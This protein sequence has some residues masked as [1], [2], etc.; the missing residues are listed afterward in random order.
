[1]SAPIVL[2][3]DFGLADPYAAQMKGAI[4][5]RAPDAP[6]VDLSHEVDPQN[7]LQAGFLL[8]VTLPHFPPGSLFVAVVDPGVGTARR[9]LC[10]RLGQNLVLAPD[11]GLLA[12]PLLLHGPPE[13][14]GQIFDCTP[15]V[16]DLAAS[17]PVAA[18][19]HGRD[20]FAPLAVRLAKGDTPESLGPEV[21]TEDLFP[22]DL[23][24]LVPADLS[25]HAT[26]TILHTDRF[27]NAVLSLLPEQEAPVPGFSLHQAGQDPVPVRRVS[28]YADLKPGEVGILPGSQG[29]LELA[30]NLDSA[31]KRLGLAPGEILTL[32]R[33]G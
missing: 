30:M 10:A 7:V 32:I 2:L 20:L 3:T 27:G 9:I 1:M 31:A 33:S 8:A 17:G 4:L 25:S 6:L 18:T 23:P 19:F 16:A 5:C 13:H 12:L 26:A 28:I 15:T 29:F 24:S 21:G 14:T 22:A 11:N